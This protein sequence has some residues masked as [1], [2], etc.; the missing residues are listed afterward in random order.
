[1]N[2]RGCCRLPRPTQAMMPWLR[3]RGL[4]LVELMIALALGLL[5]TLAS[6]SVLIWANGGFAGQ[7]DGAAIDDAG[8][9]ALDAISRAARQGAFVNWD[10]D[11]AG[12]D[13]ADGPAML[14]GLDAQSLAVRSAGLD[15][16]RP[17]VANGS[18]VLALRF[19]GSGPAPDG[20]GSVLSCAGFPVD[21]GQVG[22]SIFFVANNALGEAELRCKYRGSGAWS[23]D[24]VIAGVDSFQVLY[25]VD[26]DA[27]GDGVANRYINASAIDALDADLQL[28]GDTDAAR[29][30]DLRRRTHWKRVAGIK[31]ALLLHGRHRGDTENVPAVYQLFGP[32]YRAAVGEGDRGTLV[33]EAFLPAALRHRYRRLFVSTIM[34]RNPAS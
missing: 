23:A 25:G 6:G 12:I 7:T 19:A 31:V 1:M 15:D 21:A 28:A 8:R 2:P 20:D 10:R 4:T 9:Y 33:Y 11:D 34:L 24:A 27:P 18:D 22:W 14:A 17:G 32:D 29:A 3:Q 26:T 30:L 13:R 16:P 5:I